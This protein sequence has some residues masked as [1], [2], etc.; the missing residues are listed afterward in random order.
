MLDAESVMVEW[1]Q[2]RQYR[3][4]SPSLIQSRLEDVPANLLKE[5]EEIDSFSTLT[6]YVVDAFN[7]Q[8]NP[9]EFV[10]E[11]SASVNETHAFGD[12]DEFLREVILARLSVAALRENPTPQMWKY[13]WSLAWHSSALEALLPQAVIIAATE[14][15]FRDQ[16]FKVARGVIEEAADNPGRRAVRN[17]KKVG[18]QQRKHW[19]K[20]GQL[21]DLWRGNYDHSFHAV[22]CDDDEVLSIVAEIDITK[23]VELL[24]IYDYPNP[25]AIALEQCGV[26]RCFT[27]WKTLVEV[28][29]TA[30]SEKAIW[31]GSLILPLLL[32]VAQDELQFAERLFPGQ[33]SE[34]TDD[35]KGLAAEIAKTLAPRMDAKGCLVRWGNWLVRNTIRAVSTNAVPHPIDAMSR[36]FAD[37]ALFEALVAEI[38][39]GQ[40][41]PKPA[42]DTESWEPWCQLAAGALVALA[43]KASM[44]SP[45]EFLEEWRLSVDEW[46]ARRG[47]EL[48]LRAI[49]FEGSAPIA[50]GYGGRLLA[51]PL[52]ESGRADDRWRE[53]WVSTLTLREVVEFGDL[54][55]TDTGSWQGR[56]DAAGL[57][58]LQFNIG[59]MMLD[60]LIMPPCQLSYDRQAAI[61]NLLPCL[62]ESV[63]EMASIDQL[64]RKFWAEATRHL[65]IRRAKWLS[66]ENVV[67]GTETKPTLADFIYTLSGD[68][69][70]LLAF[71]YVALQN[72]I[73]EETIVT[74][75]NAAN[76]NI[77]A[78]IAI[79]DSMCVMS[80][81]KFA[82][83]KAQLDA[84]REIFI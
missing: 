59:L 19:Q 52:V 47:R 17:E 71:V 49:P 24:T 2:E 13:L 54:D 75:F 32:T 26:S 36:G 9:E 76:V 77:K 30:F 1:P 80:P 82:L 56:G 33:V 66:D 83:G 23:F 37:N 79:A 21:S 5:V 50:N 35:I 53:F 70:N 81:E 29:P 46:P 27:R 11:L 65:A 64:N 69:E 84:V 41:D 55:E 25:V 7:K 74:A 63:R 22:G 8:I 72:D 48:Q 62:A 18:A 42:Q 31:N 28:V 57:L 12:Y 45:E 39:A 51:I 68:T 6:Q 60:H 15:E 40:W 43:G 44:P 38:P 61:E 58:M 3:L 14:T 4:S 16:F 20:H 78:E 10:A 67:L 34:T 73:S